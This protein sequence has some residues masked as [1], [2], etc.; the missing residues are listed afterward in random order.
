MRSVDDEDHGSVV[1]GKAVHENMPQSLK[2][3]T[4]NYDR[5]PKNQHPNYDRLPKKTA[6]LQ[7]FIVE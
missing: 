2:E 7:R 4:P 5:L 3:I 6:F 1:K